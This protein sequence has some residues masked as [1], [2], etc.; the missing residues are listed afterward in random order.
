M[1]TAKSTE[2]LVAAVRAESDDLREFLWRTAAV[3][4]SREDVLACDRCEL[5]EHA[6]RVPWTGPRSQVMFVGEAPGAS[7]D[8]AGVPFVGPAGKLFD[9]A[10]TEAGMSRSDVAV[11]NTVCCRP[12]RNDFGLA[13]RTNA[14]ERCRPHREAALD[15]SGAW[16]VCLLGGTALRVFGVGQTVGQVRGSLWWGDDARL[17]TASWHPAY[18][19]RKPHKLET[20]VK[21]LTQVHGLLRGDIPLPSMTTPPVELLGVAADRHTMDRYKQAWKK[22]GWVSTFSP[23]VGRRVALVQNRDVEPPP[24]MF[25]VKLQA[26]DVARL[27]TPTNIRAAAHLAALTPTL[28]PTPKVSL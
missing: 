7:E 17:Y 21:D 3:F 28:E 16:L 24:E 12:A 8:A 10:L 15:T 23:H 25:D 14:P 9:Q 5:G 1:T 11:S 20:L 13:W 19:L 6:N 26:V 2:L 27:R 18:V 4:K 22:H